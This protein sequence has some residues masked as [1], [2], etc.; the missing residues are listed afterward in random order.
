MH[1]SPVLSLLTVKNAYK[2]CHP[3]GKREWRGMWGIGKSDI[4]EASIWKYLLMVPN[5]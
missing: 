1:P 4:K 3:R 5:L 2:F